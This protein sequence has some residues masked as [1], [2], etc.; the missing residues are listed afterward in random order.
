MSSF[1]QAKVLVVSD[2]VI[3]GTRTDNA[4]PKVVARLTDARFEVL[5]HAVTADGIDEV[6]SALRG[7]M[8]ASSISS[9]SRG[10]VISSAR[11]TN[12]HGC[13]RFSFRAAATGSQSH[14]PLMIRA[15]CCSAILLVRSVLD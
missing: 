1:L 7:L 5:E 12:T 14:S 13:F 3:A 9:R 4:G 10:G 2:G 8:A 6:A 11:G 15:P